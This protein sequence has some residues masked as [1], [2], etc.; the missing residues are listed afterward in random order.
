MSEFPKYIVVLKLPRD[1]PKIIVK[2]NVIK[3]SISNSIIY[4]TP[5]P[6][7]STFNTHIKNATTAQAGTIT[8]PPTVTANDRDKAVNSM[9]ADIKAYRV[10]CQALVNA[11]PNQASASKIA[12]SFGMHLKGSTSHGSR[13]DEIQ[14]GT[15]P[16]TA[17]YKMK[18]EGAH[19][20]QI[21]YDAGAT[22]E[23]LDSTGNG[24]T[25]LTG[26]TPNKN[27]WLRNRQILTK[28][29]YSAWT[30]WKKFS[31]RDNS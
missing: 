24:K 8:T 9:L 11:A 17:I 19:M 23:P 31:I 21:S 12:K 30:E 13:K 16:G 7:V 5:N 2:A 3:K 26:L 10:D 1:V 15:E 14:D 28:G 4:P 22:H 18:G 6:P 29:Q 25:T 27:F 20:L